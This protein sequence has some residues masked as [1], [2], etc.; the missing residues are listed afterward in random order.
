MGEWGIS[1]TRRPL[2]P[3]KSPGTYC[4]RAWV[5]SRAGLD[6]G[7]EE[8]KSHAATEVR[9]PKRP[10]RNESLYSLCYPGSTLH[11]RRITQTTV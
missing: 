2:Y 7:R 8:K 11:S 4:T 6:R 5:G 10:A 3:H 1:A 9:T